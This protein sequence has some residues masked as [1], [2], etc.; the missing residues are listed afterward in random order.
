MSSLTQIEIWKIIE[1]I[2]WF[3]MGLHVVLR[4]QKIDLFIVLYNSITS[5]QYCTK[6]WS[7]TIQFWK[8]VRSISAI[9]SLKTLNAFLLKLCFQ[10]RLSGILANYLTDLTEIYAG[11]LIKKIHWQPFFPLGNLRNPLSNSGF[12][13]MMQ[14][15]I[16]YFK[17]GIFCS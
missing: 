2:D 9:W 7:L 16:Y 1:R 4:L 8:V 10:S 3:I 11:Q 6:C 13:Y 14:K 12:W 15:K 5:L 17:I